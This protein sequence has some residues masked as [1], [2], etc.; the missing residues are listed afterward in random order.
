MSREM[1]LVIMEDALHA[2]MERSISVGETRDEQDGFVDLALG[3][4]D[5]RGQPVPLEKQRPA[6]IVL[7]DY[8]VRET[9]LGSEVA[10][11]LRQEGFGGV[12][13][14]LTGSSEA[15][16]SRLTHSAHR[17]VCALSTQCD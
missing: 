9:L 4:V 10:S 17:P 6:D 7:L 3:R 16:L 8:N 15:E 11:R 2:D 13:C 12:V 14:L 5:V 1:Q